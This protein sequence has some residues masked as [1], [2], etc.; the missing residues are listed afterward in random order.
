MSPLCALGPLSYRAQ[1]WRFPPDFFL[2]SNVHSEFPWSDEDQ[3]TVVQSSYLTKQALFWG[4]GGGGGGLIAPQIPKGQTVRVPPPQI[5]STMRV[6]AP[7]AFNEILQTQLKLNGRLQVGSW[8]SRAKCA[9]TAAQGST[10]VFTPATAARDSSRGASA[11]TGLMSANL[12]H[13]WEARLLTF[14]LSFCAFFVTKDMLTLVLLVI[15]FSP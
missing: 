11:G 8:T 5:K 1:I 2:T 13:R 9:V 10:T 15:S 6:F 7:A 14:Y 4:G 12:A 3:V